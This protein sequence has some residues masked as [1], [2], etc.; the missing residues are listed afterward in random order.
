M[1]APEITCPFCGMINCTMEH[2]E[3]ADGGSVMIM[4]GIPLDI[5]V[6]GVIGVLVLSFIAATWL[7]ANPGKGFRFN[8]IKNKRV[9]KFVRNRWFQAAPQ[10]FMVGILVALIYIGLA[11]SRIANLTPVAVW[12][13]WW[14]GLIF[15]VL[16]LGTGWCSICP[17]DGIAN[18]FTRQRLAGRSEPLTLGLRFP[19]WLKNVYPAIGLFVVLTWLELGYGVTT[20]PRTT[21]YMGLGMIGLAVATA[22]MFQ[23]KKFCTYMCPVGRICGTYSRF[24][25]IE[26]ANKRQRV[27]DKCKT[28]DC[29]NGNERGYPCPT[30]VSLRTIT[31]TSE[32][33]GCTE[34]IKSCD[35]MNVAI[36]LRP[37]G[38]ELRNVKL[39]KIDEAWLALALLTLTFFHGLSMTPL[40]EDF[41]P[42]RMSLLKWM[43]I[44]LGTSRTVNFTI[45]MVLVCTIP[46]IAYWLCCRLGAWW[47]AGEPTWRQ[48]FKNYAY[49]LLPVALFYHLS[50]NLMHL[51]MEGGHIIPMLSDPMGDGSNYFGTRGEHYDHLLTGHALWYMQVGLILIGHIVGIMVAHRSALR[52]YPDKRRAVRSLLPMLLLMIIISAGGLWL[53]HL[54][55]NMRVGRM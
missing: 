37:F 9:Y 52:L 33:I 55:M 11:G 3:I 20:N 27:C 6:Y 21:A 13:I 5:F 22:L 40:W 29:L 4:D 41:R 32:C 10:L 39:P 34:C 25:P 46:I 44:N 48:L 35:K 53:M 50:H 43:G 24:A 19:N 23:D 31:S 49:S 30:G 14:A 12:T 42:G 26:I 8:L 51:M 47:A 1:P 45:A 17:W 16:F 2:V 36:N 54:D 28:E 18:L 7:N 38:S 15:A